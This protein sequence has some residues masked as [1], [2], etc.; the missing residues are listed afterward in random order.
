MSFMGS[1]QGVRGAQAC[2]V[3]A[4]WPC[5]CCECSQQVKAAVEYETDDLLELCTLAS[6]RSMH[7]VLANKTLFELQTSRGMN[8]S[9]GAAQAQLRMLSNT[10]L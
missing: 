7:E 6:T 1:G 2:A 8:S 4:H 5:A 10:I 3:D 9:S